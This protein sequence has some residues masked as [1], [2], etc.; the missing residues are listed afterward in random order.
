LVRSGPS[1]RIES[2]TVSEGSARPWLRVLRAGV[3]GTDLQILRGLR[4]D[5]AQVLGHEGVAEVLV[6]R[7]NLSAKHVI[8]NPVDV[9]NQDRILGHSEDG[10]FAQLILPTAGTL[11]P[12]DPSL[13]ID[14]CPL[15]EPLS[16]VLYA[17]ELLTLRQFP[18]E[19]G[20]WGGGTA[21]ILIALIADLNGSRCHI[22]HRRQKRLNWLRARLPLGTAEWYCYSDTDIQNSKPFLD[23]AILATACDGAGEALAQATHL[24]RDD[25]I[26][27][28]FGGFTLSDTSPDLP[29]LDLGS[30]RRANA[31]GKVQLGSIRVHRKSGGYVWITGHR[32]SSDRQLMKSQS[33]LINHTERFSTLVT[34][35]ISLKH[36]AAFLPLLYAH[37]TD[38]IDFLKIVID[39]TLHADSRE[40][41]LCMR[42]RD[43]SLDS[44]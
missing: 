16:T 24:V 41:D 15:V 13:I 37:T 40:P 28:L 3:C 20:I 44:S 10:I 27:D 42:L 12:A 21:A 38:S 14:L 4:P 30:V 9:R 43:V 19:V 18:T 22:F 11:V 5:N 25:G 23:A 33:L 6:D 35:V 32:G 36:A 31:S 17:W 1:L 39:P 2:R 8:F 34:H 7:P 29:G 26:L